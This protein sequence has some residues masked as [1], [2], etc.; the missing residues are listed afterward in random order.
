MWIKWQLGKYWNGY[1]QSK[2]K[3]RRYRKTF[4]KIWNEYAKPKQA[5]LLATW[6]KGGGEVPVSPSRS[7]YIRQTPCFLC[8]Q[9]RVVWVIV[10]A[11][12]QTNCNNSAWCR[13][14]I[15]RSASTENLLGCERCSLV[16]RAYKRCGQ[17]LQMAATEWTVSEDHVVSVNRCKNLKYQT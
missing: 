4:W 5:L 12:T 13:L 3:W 11:C 7:S 6:N 14:G 15:Q 16:V 1:L 10:V 9:Q 8:L 17:T 2:L